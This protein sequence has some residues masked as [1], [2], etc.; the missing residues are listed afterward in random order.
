MERITLIVSVTVLDP[1]SFC[2]LIVT[3]CS[4]TDWEGVPEMTPLYT[5][6]DNPE[7]KEPDVIE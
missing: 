1:R 6:N 5:F 4:V 3:C 2:A 7:G